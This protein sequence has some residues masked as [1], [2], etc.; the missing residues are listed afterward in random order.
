MEQEYERIDPLWA[1]GNYLF[2]EGVTDE[3]CARAMRFITYHNMKESKLDSLT[4]VINSPGGSVSAAMALIDVMKTSNIPVNTL[5][6]GS[7]A[8]CG[9][10]LTMSGKKR[11][12]SEN[13]QVMSHQYSW[14]KSGKHSDLLAN[15][16]AEDMMH[17]LLI[18]HYVHCTKKTRK[19]VEKNLLPH[20]DVWMTAYEAV[21]MGIVDEV[22]EIY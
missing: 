1:S 12:I 16:K 14:G 18:K 22:R 13:C 5:A 17:E 11:Q 3:S 7:I 15:R 9:V 19:F 10:L 2:Q 8:S 6:V 4:L 20:H 21:E